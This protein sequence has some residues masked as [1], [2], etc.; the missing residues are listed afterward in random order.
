MK[1][2][3]DGFSIIEIVIVLAVISII[4]GLCWMAFGRSSKT[5]KE[6]NAPVTSQS[7]ATRSTVEAGAC[8]GLSKN[9]I[10]SLLG[11]PANNLAGPS[12]TGVKDIGKGDKAQT[13][14]YP[15]KDGATANNSFMIDLGTYAN[16]SN[17]DASQKYIIEEGGQVTGLGDNASYLAKDMPLLNTR[18][19]V[20]TIRQ[21]LKIYKFEISQPIDATTYNDASAQMVLIKIAQAATL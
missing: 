2:Q 6:S 5:V 17:L 16:Q 12:D 10:K 11:E 4:V 20:L 9:T 8:F 13:C 19:Y 18:D 14:V 1:K 7:P 3:T 15:F 21:D